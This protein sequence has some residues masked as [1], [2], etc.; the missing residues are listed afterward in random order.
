MHACMYT[1]IYTYIYDAYIFTT[2]HAHAPARTHTGNS[3][4]IC[5]YT[6][7]QSY[8]AQD[9]NTYRLLLRQ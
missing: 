8:R 2:L 3:T 5:M 1:Y 6:Q 9:S 4:Y 7:L